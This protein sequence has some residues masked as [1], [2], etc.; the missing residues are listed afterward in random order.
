MENIKINNLSKKNILIY[1]HDYFNMIS[2]GITVHYYFAKLLDEAGEMVRMHPNKGSD[3]NKLFNKYY[4]NDFPIDEN[5][6]VIYCEGIRGNPLNAPN[7]VRWMLSERGQNTPYDIVD[8]WGKNELIYFFNSE[9]MINENP[10]KQGNIYK[11]LTFIYLDDEVK[12]YNTELKRENCCHAFK[13]TQIHKNG[14]DIIHPPHS[15]EVIKYNSQKDCVDIFNRY[16]YFICYDPISFITI[17]AA[18]CGCISI[19]CPI[20]G[21]DELTW[22]KIGAI[23]EYIEKNNINK[24]YGIAYGLENIEW[25]KSTLHL[26]KQQWEDITKY[27]A[28]KHIPIFIKDIN[29]FHENQNT[30][31]NVFYK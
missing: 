17:M 9:K 13:K 18:I 29:N 14:F 20:H 15:F 6:V 11:F 19:V 21:I 2:G 12:K 30:I 27:Y 3:N 1:P 25:A 24:L 7:V 8:T 31:E 16:E 10:E 5:S 26:V 4:N 23:K 28:N 22:I